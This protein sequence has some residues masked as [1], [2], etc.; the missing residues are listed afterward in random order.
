MPRAAVE[1]RSED[2]LDAALGLLRE[3]GLPGVTTNALA[4]RAR[5]SKDTLYT[6]FADRDAILAALIRRQAASLNERMLAETAIDGMNDR[7]RLVEA[8]ALLYALLLSEASLAI[9][10]A[11]MADGSGA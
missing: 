6:L 7:A 4:A 5:C 9:N 10:R 2:I 1:T 3:K 8:G 11:A